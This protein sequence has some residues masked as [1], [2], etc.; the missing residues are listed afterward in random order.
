MS[1]K[2]F[3][4]GT[5]YDEVNATVSVM[6]RGFL[7]GDGIYEV[8]A[9]VNGRPVDRERH[10]QR[11]LR[12]AQEIELDLIYSSGDLHELIDSV[13]QENQLQEGIVYIQISRGTAERDFVFPQGI[14]QT[15]VAFSQRK[16]LCSGIRLERGISAMTVADLRWKRRDIKSTSLVAQVLPKLAASRAGCDEA[17]LHDDGLV[18]EGASTT[19]FIV[20]GDGALITRPLSN[21]VLP[22]ITRRAILDLCDCG[23]LPVIERT[24]TVGELLAASEVFLVGATF[25]VVPVTRIDGTVVGDGKRG[26]VTT[27]LQKR[28]I[29]LACDPCGPFA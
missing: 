20:N 1:R 18:T 17:I 16:V 12:S 9:V 2:I 25:F 10:I 8:C 13:I 14:V 11:L 6:D 7:F 4:N 26:E 21:E 24:F 28:Y 15:T 23:N 27:A 19:V 5:F 29:D 3:V 22:S